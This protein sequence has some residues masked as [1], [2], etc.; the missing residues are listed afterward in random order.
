VERTRGDDA[1]GPSVGP[2]SFHLRACGGHVSMAE[3]LLNLGDIGLV[4]EG[5]G[6]GGRARSDC[7]HSSLTP[8]LMP[9][10]RPYWRTMLR[11]TEA[12]SRVCPGYF[13]L[14]IRHGGDIS[15]QTSCKPHGRWP[16][17]SLPERRT[18]LLWN[19]TLAFGC[20]P[21]QCGV[22]GSNPAAAS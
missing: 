8:A 16:C 12:G 14:A 1:A 15:V 9:V 17:L 22:P 11:Y 20:Q 4:Q 13:A 19:Q 6:S 10:S 5:V 18:S 7:T 2:I 21:L 3:P